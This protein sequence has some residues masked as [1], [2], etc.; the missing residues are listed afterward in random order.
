MSIRSIC[1][2]TSVPVLRLEHFHRL[3]APV[4]S[5]EPYASGPR[6]AWLVD[7][8]GIHRG[9]SS[10]RHPEGRWPH[11]R[12]IHIAVHS[13]WLSQVESCFSIPQRKAWTP[14]DLSSSEETESRVLG[15]QDQYR[16]AA[17]PF[18]WTLSRHDLPRL[19]A[20]LEAT[21]MTPQPLAA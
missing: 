20:R 14:D 10:I 1:S 11:L 12:L 5:Q 9:K 21:D 6:L 19:L 13:S 16:T 8:A 15:L 3:V 18:D 4:M 7:T 2:V 17:R